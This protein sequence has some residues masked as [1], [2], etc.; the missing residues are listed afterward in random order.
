MR[1]DVLA[2]V[3]RQDMDKSGYQVS[4]LEDVQF[5]WEDRDLNIDAVLPWHRYSLFPFNDFEMVS[6]AEDEILIDEVQDN[7]NSP[8]LPTTPVTERPTQTTV[9]KRGDPFGATIQYSPDHVYRNL[10]E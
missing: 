1:D 10:F 3:G 2:S 9:L 5:H 6:M 8:P 7:E 4:D